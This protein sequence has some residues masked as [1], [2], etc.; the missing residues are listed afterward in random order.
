MIKMHIWRRKWW[1]GAGGGEGGAM[2]VMFVMLPC[3]WGW[4]PLFRTVVILFILPGC[5]RL[6]LFFPPMVSCKHPV[7]IGCIGPL[8]LIPLRN[9]EVTGDH[10][11][12][13][14]LKY[15]WNPLESM[16]THETSSKCQLNP[17]EIPSKFCQATRSPLKSPSCNVTARLQAMPFSQAAMAAL[18]EARENPSPTSYDILSCSLRC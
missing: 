9:R 18:P 13:I 11:P 1:G 12:M 5:S 8:P 14:W 10:H 4:L 2:F 17:S 6:E 16:K 3:W 7:V 15:G